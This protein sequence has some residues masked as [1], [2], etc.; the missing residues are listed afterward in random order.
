M[1]NPRTIARLEAQILRR[2]AHCLQFEISDPRA[3]FITLTKVELSKDLGHAKVLYSVLGD[4]SDR[5]KAAQM[6]ESAGGFIQRQVASILKTRTTPR[7]KFLYDDSLA[8]A[9]RLDQLIREARQRDREINP[10][11]DGPP[12][13]P[14]QAAQASEPEGLGDTSAS[15]EPG[16]PGEPDGP[17]S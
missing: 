8:E 11:G 17:L 2:A 15:G 7:L 5:S 4:E 16:E 3:T 12:G 6:F 10:G 13:D 14:G 9:Q 1:A